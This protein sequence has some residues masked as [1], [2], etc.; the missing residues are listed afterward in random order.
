[1]KIKNNLLT[2]LYIL[3]SLTVIIILVILLASYKIKTHHE[4]FEIAHRTYTALSELNIITYEFLLHHEKRMQDQWHLKFNSVKKMLETE[5]FL[6]KE[7]P[8]DLHFISKKFLSLEGLFKQVTASF[9]KH[10]KFIDNGF[11]QQKID[12]AAQ[13]HERTIIQLLINSQSLFF[14]ISNFFEEKKSQI[15]NIQKT[16]N[17]LTL[18]IIM[19]F[20]FTVVVIL[21]LLLSTITKPLSM[22]IQGSRIIG[23][24]NFDHKVTIKTNNEF[25]DLANSFNEMA[26]NLNLSR[27][28]TLKNNKKLEL[29]NEE[30]KQNEKK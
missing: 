19:I 23:E 24:G 15:I 20:T 14:T 22:L 3:L 13:L 1:M 29:L 6:T 9:N 10:Q 17:L 25:A 30:L 16:A 12:L 4:K 28:K 26:V 7:S 21:L 18:I 11:P 8:F 2:S 27:I 5:R